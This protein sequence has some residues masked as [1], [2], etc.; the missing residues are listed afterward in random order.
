MENSVK[1]FPLIG[2]KILK[3]LDN[4]S[5]VRAKKASKVI[6]KFLDNE[7]VYWIRIIKKYTG[8][9]EKHEESWNTIFNKTP[10]SFIKKLAIETQMFFKFMTDRKNV[11]PLHI[12]V[13]N[14]HFEICRLIIEKVENKN[15]TDDY[16]WT[17]FHF[18]ARYGFYDICRLFINKV[19]DKNP[20]NK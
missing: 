14:G 9:F 19:E 10:S 4:Q 16:G 2:E 15:P 5:L 18:A 6:A 20:A 11:S 1:R 8:K 12:A 3:N 7:K 13:Q 17:P